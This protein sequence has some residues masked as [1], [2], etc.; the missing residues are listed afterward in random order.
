VV[1]P[2]CDKISVKFDPSCFLTI[3]VPAKERQT[4]STITLVRSK[5]EGK[6]WAK[7]VLT[8]TNKTTVREAIGA[9]KENLKGQFAPNA[10]IVLLSQYNSELMDEEAI[11]S[12]T[13]GYNYSPNVKQFYAF[14]VNGQGPL[15]IVHSKS[16]GTSYEKPLGRWEL[17]PVLCSTS[18]A[19]IQGVPLVLDVPK[20]KIS[21]Q[22]INETIVPV[23]GDILWKKQAEENWSGD[24]K[25][26]RLRSLRSSQHQLDKDEAVSPTEVVLEVDGRIASLDDADQVGLSAIAETN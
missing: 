16:T 15:V 25:E 21:R 8:H 11:L 3:P 12:P 6:P 19:L 14:A 7:F 26:E 5:S 4:R 22:I 23:V 17:W 24:E 13:T 9:I 18:I 2:V 1:C 20:K 10:R